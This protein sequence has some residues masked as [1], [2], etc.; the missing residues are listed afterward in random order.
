M[1]HKIDGIGNI[2]I[3]PGILR[4]YDLLGRYH[5]RG[6]RPATMA[7]VWRMDY[8]SQSVVSRFLNQKPTAETIAVLVV[9]Y[10][11]LNCK[12]R[13]EALPHI[14][15]LGDKRTTAKWINK[16][17]RTISRVVVHPRWRSMGLAVQ[18]VAH[19]IQHNS[20]RYLEALAVMGRVHPFF[21]KAGMQV[22]R[23][24]AGQ[25]G[26]LYYLHDTKHPK[27]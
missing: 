21:E 7:Q 18:L 26:P 14:N 6:G 12:G 9:S 22:Y 27:G 13:R 8:L 17:I 20:T 5:Y 10:P 19:A 25:D 11:S 16:N 15:N 23:E 2:E 3:H 24:R 1:Q 4:D